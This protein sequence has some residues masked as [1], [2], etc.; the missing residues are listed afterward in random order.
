MTI[1]ANR[2]FCNRRTSRYHGSI[3]SSSDNDG[4]NA[5]HMSVSITDRFPLLSSQMIGMPW[6][7]LHCIG[8]VVVVFDGKLYV[9]IR[10]IQ[11]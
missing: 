6:L 4:V 7:M 2:N 8:I 3:K 10:N 11:N 5:W 9:E 1:I